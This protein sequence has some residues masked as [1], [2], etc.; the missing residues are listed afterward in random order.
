[1]IAPYPSIDVYAAKRQTKRKKDASKARSKPELPPYTAPSINAYRPAVSAEQ[2]EEFMASI[3]GDM[4]NTAVTVPVPKPSRKR[5]SSPILEPDSSPVKWNERQQP[6][7]DLSSDGPL[8][9]LASSDDHSPNK[10]AR[11]DDPDLIPATERLA[12]L[13]V[14]SGSDDFDKYDDF[15]MDDFME[16]DDVD[17]DFKPTIKKEEKEEN[18]PKRVMPKSTNTTTKAE[19]LK[20][21]WLSVY[22]SLAVDTEDALGP[23]SS[24]SKASNTSSASVLEDDGSF[25]FFW[26][27]YLELEG[28]LYF[29]GKVKDKATDTWVSCC[30]TVENIER[31]LYVLPREK[32]V[33][34]VDDALMDTD[35]VPPTEDIH[36]DFD[37]IRKQM[38]IKSWRGK[39]VKRKY[40]FGEEDIPRGVSQWMKVVYSFNGQSVL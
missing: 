23:L 21:N 1:L 25:R 38:G 17:V 28:R 6:F 13:G 16:I 3:L 27:D 7:V 24:H 33:E 2:E 11:I 31:N 12:N 36:D 4:D 26:L 15:S 22:E 9:D 10:R 20:P 34:L 14:E 19:D 39:F 30:V 32:R 35:I 40:V 5:K 29:T 8:E 18:I 37:T